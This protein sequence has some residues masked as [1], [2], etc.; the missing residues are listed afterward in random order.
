ML[1]KGLFYLFIFISL[2]GL[3]QDKNQQK[4]P[5]PT[6]VRTLLKD[7]RTAI[8][9]KRDQKNK[10]KALFD[11]L[12]RDDISN[13]EKA[14]IYYT[15][16]ALEHSLNDQ[17]NLKAYLKQ[18]YDT[19]N[20][21]NTMLLSAQYALL[22]D[23]LDTLPNERGKIKAKYRSRN[24]EQILLYRPNIYLGGRFFLRKGDYKK[25]FDF[26]SMYSDFPRQ[27][28]ISS[29]PKMQNDTLLRQ[30]NYY[31]VF[32]AYNSKN[33]RKALHYIDRAISY[34]DSA[35]SPVLQEY[36]VR[37]LQET[38]QTDSWLKELQAG[39][40]DYPRHDYFFVNMAKYY[41]DNQMADECIALADSMLEHVQDATIYWYSK[42]LMHLHKE[43]WLKSA[44][45]AE[46]VLQRE[47]EHINALYN[48]A[49]SYVNEASD[50]FINACTD[51]RDP[52]SKADREHIQQL[53]R[54]A[55]HPSEEIRRLR[56]DAVNTW[57]PLLYRIYLN[58]NMGTEF[59]EMEKEMKALKK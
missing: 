4:A 35:Q 34:A 32:A 6:P 47:P 3:A 26:M 21:Y 44:E 9:N 30:S 15:A 12:K 14:E 45:M 42:S 59:S 22:C 24:R 19:A 50:C 51:V 17:E 40:R 49:V 46:I 39:V 10:E 1:R 16:S 33:P 53:Y 7:A 23:S 52:R 57:A 37:C 41:E 31:A 28:I 36:K 54:K 18:K 27:M 8:K 38:Q 5:K 2:A 11:A 48:M 29:H 13:A 56:P 43:E 25:A 20:Y 55:L 58:L